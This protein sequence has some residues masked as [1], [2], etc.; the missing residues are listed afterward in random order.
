MLMEVGTGRIR[1]MRQTSPRCSSAQKNWD[2][3]LVE[4]HA[5]AEW[6][7]RNVYLLHS[8]I[9]LTL[10]DCTDIDW[11]SGGQTFS[12]QLGPGRISILPAHHPYSVRVRASGGSIVV[13]LEQKLL[14]CAAAEQGLFGDI[15]PIW[16]HGV[17][18]ALMRELVLALRSE[19]RR[20]RH[21]NPGYAQSL[22]SALAA[23][24]IQRY[25]TDHLSFR[26]QSGG[27]TVAALRTAIQLIQDHLG[28]EIS[29]EWL[30]AKV[31]L[32]SAH[33]ARMFKQTTGMSPHQY[34]L[35]CRTGRAQQ[36]LLNPAISLAE[37]AALA[38][39]CDQGHMT[40]SFRQFLGTTPSVY[41]RGVRGV[42]E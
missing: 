28:E 26:D 30:A 6:Q 31:H 8:A 38:G 20:T 33:F 7:S 18:D 17:E 22:A 4:D 5:P 11:R 14:S 15:Q 21:D 32:S 34:V 41:A 37:V 25:S 42:N 36:L 9:Y 24:V 13:A 12:R 29:I 40:R 35:H 2:G 27:L 3:F 10:D 23:H 16:V 39:F 1:P 19:A